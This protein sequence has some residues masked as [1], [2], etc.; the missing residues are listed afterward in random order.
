MFIE[1][2][3]IPVRA[4]RRSYLC[5]QC[6]SPDIEFT[7]QMMPMMPPLFQ[8]VCK[9]C[10]A[11]FALQAQTGQVFFV[12]DVQPGAGKTYEATVEPASQAHA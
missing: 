8:H 5:P 9:V 11:G 1:F 4:V 12:E 3:D 7:G 2:R 6:H 10:R